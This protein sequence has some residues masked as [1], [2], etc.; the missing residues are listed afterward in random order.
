VQIGRA[1]FFWRRYVA[2]TLGDQERIPLRIPK[3]MARKLGI[4]ERLPD[5]SISELV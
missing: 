5:Y 4:L 2:L 3:G 1:T